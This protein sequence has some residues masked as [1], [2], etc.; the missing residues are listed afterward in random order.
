MNRI[1]SLIFEYGIDRDGF[2]KWFTFEPVVEETPLGD[3]VSVSGFITREPIV[4]SAIAALGEPLDIAVLG[5]MDQ[6]VLMVPFTYEGAVSNLREA[7]L[8]LERLELEQGGDSA[9]LVTRDWVD[10]LLVSVPEGRTSISMERLR[11]QTIPTP[12]YR[13]IHPD[14]TELVGHWIFEGTH[15]VADKTCKRIEFLVGH[16]LV[17]VARSPEELTTLFRDPM[18]QRLW[19]LAYPQSALHGGGPP[20]LRCVPP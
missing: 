15:C 2:S 13:L 18:D 10:L 7:A 20:A 14:E 3:G 19:E 1:E 12:P 4:Q 17:E 5:W 16:Y 11:R 9:L 6:A 8:R